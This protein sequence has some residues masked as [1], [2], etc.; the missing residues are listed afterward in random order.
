MSLKIIS[1]S[2]FL[3]GSLATV[4]SATGW[5]SKN[6]LDPV[7]HFVLSNGLSSPNAEMVAFGGVGLTTAAVMSCMNKFKYMPHVLLPANGML[8]AN[9]LHMVASSAGD[10]ALITSG[11]LLASSNSFGGFGTI[12]YH[13]L[14]GEIQPD[15]HGAGTSYAG[16]QIMAAGACLNDA[17]LISIGSAFTIDGCIRAAGN[18]RGWEP[19][20][21]A[22]KTL[23]FMKSDAAERVQTK[24]MNEPAPKHDNSDINPPS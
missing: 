13:M 8:T 2:S 1:N 3:A 22:L 12:N 11:L 5:V 16:A 6:V 17:L 21:D 19:Y 10:P 4:E 24:T 15:T 18:D 23:F 7:G 9:G 14:R 20:K